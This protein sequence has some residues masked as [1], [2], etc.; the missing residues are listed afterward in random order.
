MYEIDLN[1]DEN[2]ST[3]TK[4]QQGRGRC[5]CN[6]VMVS[7]PTGQRDS[8]GRRARELWGRESRHS[9]P[10]SPLP[11]LSP[12]LPAH[13]QTHTLT[14]LHTPTPHT[15]HMDPAGLTPSLSEEGK[16]RSLAPGGPALAMVKGVEWRG[17]SSQ[18]GKDTCPHATGPW[19]RPGREQEG[20]EAEQGWAPGLGGLPLAPSPRRGRG[21]YD[22]ETDLGYQKGPWGLS[23]SQAASGLIVYS[24][25]NAFVSFIDF[26]YKQNKNHIFFRQQQFSR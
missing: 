18:V 13:T 7:R 23:R 6:G 22:L 21:S 4:S 11:V 12:L 9:Q 15:H 19:L 20:W 2:K 17:G 16:T 5:G 26:K 24:V 8:G 1:Q 10:P 3:K 25:T 14:R